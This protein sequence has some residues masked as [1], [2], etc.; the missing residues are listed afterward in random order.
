MAR[1]LL[2]APLEPVVDAIEGRV[3]AFLSPWVNA[4]DVD[5]ELDEEDHLD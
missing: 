1:P 5:V 2:L 3:Q 4:L